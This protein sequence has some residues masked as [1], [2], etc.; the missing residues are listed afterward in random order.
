MD[1]QGGLG[2][3]QGEGKIDIIISSKV[4]SSIPEVTPQ[5]TSGVLELELG[6]EVCSGDKEL[7]MSPRHDVT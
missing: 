4:A 3:C 7:G 5:F 1:V 6:F 2:N